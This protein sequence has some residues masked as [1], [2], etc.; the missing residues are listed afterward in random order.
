[1][2][3]GH[4]VSAHPGIDRENSMT[5]GRQQACCWWFVAVDM[6]QPPLLPGCGENRRCEMAKPETELDVKSK[7]IDKGRPGSRHRSQLTP[8]P[9]AR[10]WLSRRAGRITGNLEDT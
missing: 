10:G 4:D 8:R 5:L 1:V 3:R 9:P 6:T 2:E 7:D